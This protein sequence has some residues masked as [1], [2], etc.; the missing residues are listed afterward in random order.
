M[1]FDPSIYFLWITSLLLQGAACW[2]VVKK[3]YF[4]H[5]KAFGYYLFLV[6]AHTAVMLPLSF[7]HNDKLYAATYTIGDFVEALLLS[8]VVLEILVHV[9]E[10]FE[11]LPGRTVARLCFWAVLGISVAVVLSVYVPNR[12]NLKPNLLVDLPLTLERTIFLADAA[13]LWVLLFQARALGI[14]WKSSLAEI[15]IGFVLYLTVQSTTRFVLGI[16]DNSTAR[17]LAAE[18]AQFSYLIA[19]ASW[20]WTM[21]HRDP[22]PPRP[23]PETLARLQ[24]LTKQDYDAVPRERILAAVGIK[25]NRPL[26]EEAT[27]ESVIEPEHSTV[28]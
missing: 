28:R 1:K 11:S 17:T 4:A 24:E 2:F 22:V 25:V 16:Y 10:P 12:P 13:I 23:A 14:T 3:N 9:L 5:W 18:V 7:L 20:I 19:L 6:T 15:T 8:L 26:Q 27:D 21:T